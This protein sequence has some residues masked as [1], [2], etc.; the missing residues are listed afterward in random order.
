MAMAEHQALVA[1]RAVLH[2]TTS[3][4]MAQRVALVVQLQTGAVAVAVALAQLVRMQERLA[5]T[6]VTDVHHPSLVSPPHMPAVVAAVVAT[7]ANQ[8][9]PLHLAV[10]AE[11]AVAVTVDHQHGTERIVAQAQEL[12]ER[13]TPVA[14]AVAAATA[15]PTLSEAITAAAVA[16]DPESLSCAMCFLRLQLPTLQLVQTTELR[17]LTTSPQIAP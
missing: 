13:Q 8:V 11:P 16:V 10:T 12:V 1:A 17:R 3:V 7:A 6:A 9:P 14:V 2:T 5:V 4:E 15:H